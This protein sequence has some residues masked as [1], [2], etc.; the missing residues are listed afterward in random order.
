[1]ESLH[2]VFEVVNNGLLDFF[3]ACFKTAEPKKRKPWA[4]YSDKNTPSRSTVTG[5]FYL[6]S[7]F[8]DTDFLS[9]SIATYQQN[10]VNWDTVYA[11]PAGSSGSR[12]N[13]RKS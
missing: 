6:Q 13:E 1:M 5:A 2:A 10:S 7:R 9:A 8:D 12:K 3:K 4:G 11:Y